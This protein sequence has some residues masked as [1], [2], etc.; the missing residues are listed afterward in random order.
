MS[1]SLVNLLRRDY[2]G[3]APCTKYVNS[4]HE[5]NNKIMHQYQLYQEQ[6][7]NTFDF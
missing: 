6:R 7:C 4:L 1:Y 5:A 3:Q 2:E